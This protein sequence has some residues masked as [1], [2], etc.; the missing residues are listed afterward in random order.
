MY[1]IMTNSLCPC[2]DLK[3]TLLTR[4]QVEEI[5][6][7]IS[8]KVSENVSKQLEKAMSSEMQSPKEKKNK[9]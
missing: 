8:N 1:D 3:G 4:E 5:A 9:E 2:S 6:T 7:R